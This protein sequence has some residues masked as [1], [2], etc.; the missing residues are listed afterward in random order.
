[1]QHVTHE[2]GKGKAGCCGHGDQ[3]CLFRAF[4]PVHHSGSACPLSFPGR[5]A[6]TP[7]TLPRSWAVSFIHTVLS[8]QNPMAQP[9]WQKWCSGEPESG[10]HGAT[11]VWAGPSMAMRP[12]PTALLCS[13]EP[14]GSPEGASGFAT[15]PEP[16][17]PLPRCKMSLADGLDL[18]PTETW[19]NFPL[20]PALQIFNSTKDMSQQ[21]WLLG[22]LLPGEV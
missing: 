14:Q 13:G 9:R 8:H 6:H 20:T 18:K 17:Q 2:E 16:L 11:G 1:M 4:H 21:Q 22:V 15:S 3:T 10:G 5:R 19:A 7:L 12:L